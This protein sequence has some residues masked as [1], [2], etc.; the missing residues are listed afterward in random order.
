MFESLSNITPA[1]YTLVLSFN[2]EGRPV[3]ARHVQRAR[4]IQM[5]IKVLLSFSFF[6]SVPFDCLCQ[7][8]H[9]IPFEGSA[10]RVLQAGP[11]HG[12]VADSWHCRACSLS[13][14]SPR[15][16]LAAAGTS[17]SWGRQQS[18]CPPCRVRGGTRAAPP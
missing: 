17:Q 5:K 1:L 10:P 7:L 8:Q 2:S 6:P 16:L 3:A 13:S 4:F 9:H 12:A 15:A 11:W 14:S 18:P